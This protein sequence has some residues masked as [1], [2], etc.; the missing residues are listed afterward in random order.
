MWSMVCVASRENPQI[1]MRR[2]PNQAG[3]EPG[4]L[5]AS[6]MRADLSPGSAGRVHRDL[7][8]MKKTTV[9]LRCRP[10]AIAGQGGHS[11]GPKRG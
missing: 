5:D 7:T 3:A 6:H 8:G 1:R 10:E 2:S 11:G 4:P 9:Y